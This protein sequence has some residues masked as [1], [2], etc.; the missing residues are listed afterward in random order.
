MA[1]ITETIRAAMRGVIRSLPDSAQQKIADAMLWERFRILENLRRNT[2][3]RQ[4]DA[5]L[6]HFRTYNGDVLRRCILETG[7]PWDFIEAPE[8]RIPGMLSEREKKY[9]GY[10]TGFYTGKGAAVEIGTWLGMST[11][12]LV[13]SLRKNPAFRGTLYCFDDY[14]WRS[15]SNDKWLAGT[16]Y[17]A[18]PNYTSFLPMF[19]EFAEKAGVRQNIQPAAV[20][21]SEFPGNQHLPQFNW[22]GGPIELC[23]VDCGRTLDVNEA[24]WRTTESSFIPGR[25]LLVMQDWQAHKAVPEVF[26]ENTKLFTDR[27]LQSL[28][29]IHEL[30]EAMTA[31]FLYRGPTQ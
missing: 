21:L 10:V 7:Q 5:D 30:P 25:T 22:S 6:S 14:I 4:M 2:A 23:V 17:Q 13:D 9:Y 12:Y 24:W 29:L 3:R 19:E 27:R 20:K 11:F 26:W 31:T 1:F 18:P 16:P 28:E 15:S 8:C